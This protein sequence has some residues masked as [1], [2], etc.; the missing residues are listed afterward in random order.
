MAPVISER[1]AT[2]FNAA[3]ADAAERSNTPAYV[4]LPKVEAG[5]CVAIS[6]DFG[7]VIGDKE[8]QRATLASRLFSPGLLL[9]LEY[10]VNSK[11]TK[12]KKK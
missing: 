9:V 7:I 1:Q 12:S 5:N 4:E 11:P 2:A 8:R 6:D 3:I 10:I